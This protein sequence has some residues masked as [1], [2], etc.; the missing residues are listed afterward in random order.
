MV[1][2]EPESLARE[3]CGDAVTQAQRPIAVSAWVRF[4]GK[5]ERVQ[6]LAIAWT[7][8]AVCVEWPASPG[9]HRAWL[10]ASAV[11]RI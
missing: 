11:D 3:Q 10:W 7:K 6:G 8:V 9:V 4:D 2:P 1:R 5:P